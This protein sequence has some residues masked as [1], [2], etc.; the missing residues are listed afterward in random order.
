L[1]QMKNLAGE[2]ML[3]DLRQN[4][5]DFTAALETITQS[6]LAF[7]RE[8]AA[9]GAAGIFYAVQHATANLLSEAEFRAFGREYDLRILEVTQNFWLNVMH[10]HGDNVYF[11]AVADYPLQV[12]NWHDR[13]T[14]PSLKDGLAKIKGAACGGIA[15]DMVMLRGRP[16]AVREQ[17]EEAIA[18]TNGRRY[19]VGTG[20]VTMI[21]TPEI[22]IRT[23][24]ECAHQST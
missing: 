11:D 23:A 16:E 6:T 3:I 19:I 24:I 9:T 21:P 8:I 13:E 18:Q 7:A 17:V 1:A 15:R 14:G 20:C 22:N 4:T 2:R 5:A 12:W 10:I